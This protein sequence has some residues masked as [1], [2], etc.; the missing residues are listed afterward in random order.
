MN[1]YKL[2]IVINKNAFCKWNDKEIGIANGCFAGNKFAETSGDEYLTEVSGE[3]FGWIDSN[4]VSYNESKYTMTRPTDDELIEAL[5]N[6]EKLRK[7]AIKHGLISDRVTSKPKLGNI[8]RRFQED[9]LDAMDY[10]QDENE[11]YSEL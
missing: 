9:A 8:E 5:T 3:S 6:N 7:V 4:G 10:G 11:L 1:N 2:T